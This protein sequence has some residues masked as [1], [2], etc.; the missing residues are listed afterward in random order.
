[1]LDLG[2]IKGS[3]AKKE[4]NPDFW[5]EDD[6]DLVDLVK[7]VERLRRQHEVDQAQI[8]AYEKALGWYA[9]P[10]NWIEQVDDRGRETLRWKW[11]AD[12]GHMAKHALAVW[13]ESRKS[14]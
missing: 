14:V 12:D 9:D 11:A 5:T 1:M 10:A 8:K 6:D 3:L 4:K 13:R 7:E 2:P